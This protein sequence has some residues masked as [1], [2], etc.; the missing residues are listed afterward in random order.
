MELLRERGAPA[1]ERLEVR[2]VSAV[3]RKFGEETRAT[4]IENACAEAAWKFW[5]YDRMRAYAQARVRA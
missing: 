1:H 2:D 5:A 4:G 3:K